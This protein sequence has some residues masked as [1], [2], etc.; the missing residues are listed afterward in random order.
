MRDVRR[1]IVMVC[2][3]GLVL[4]LGASACSGGDASHPDD[5]S[6]QIHGSI[7]IP[8]ET[9]SCQEMHLPAN[10]FTLVFRD[11][12]DV[13]IGTTTI[14]AAGDL[15]PSDGGCIYSAEYETSV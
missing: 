3:G 1:R 5:G 7:S 10:G 14:Q 9:L 12:T 11:E 8:F 6:V 15:T 2:S 13:I 4:F